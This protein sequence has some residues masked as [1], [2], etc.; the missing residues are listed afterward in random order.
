MIFSPVVSGKSTSMITGADFAWFPLSNPGIVSIPLG[1]LLGVLGTYL[2][3]DKSAA[4]RY[5]E[6]SVRALTGAGAEGVSK[7]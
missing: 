7:H 6:L 4:N 5:N 2:G 3:K 1:F